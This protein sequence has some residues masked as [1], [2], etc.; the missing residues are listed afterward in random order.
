MTNDYTNDF[1]TVP[2]DVYDADVQP[3]WTDQP[4]TV[5][6]SAWVTLHR[7]WWEADKRAETMTTRWADAN[8]KTRKLENENASLRGDIQ[9]MLAVTEG[10][11]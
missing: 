8:E 3:A 1:A 2:P 10:G 5:P 4:I 9:A 7:K 11:E 6:L